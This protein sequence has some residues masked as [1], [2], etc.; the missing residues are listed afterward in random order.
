MVTRTEIIKR[1]LCGSTNTMVQ[2]FGESQLVLLSGVCSWKNRRWNVERVLTNPL[3][4]NCSYTVLIRAASNGV[5]VTI[6][7]KRQM[8]TCL[9]SLPQ[10]SNISN[11]NGNKKCFWW[12][13]SC[14]PPYLTLGYHPQG[15]KW[16]KHDSRNSHV[17]FARNWDIHSRFALAPELSIIEIKTIKS[18]WG[19]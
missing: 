14:L 17:D 4:V 2:H 10:F 18:C 15:E 13:T 6:G 3:W 7:C 1:G 16:R 8:Q 11:L 5:R 19:R 9:F 12:V